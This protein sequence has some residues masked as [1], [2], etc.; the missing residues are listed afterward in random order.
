L[1]SSASIAARV[2]GVV[3]VLGYLTGAVDGPVLGVLGGLALLTFG[4][5]LAARPGAELIAPASFGILAGA[6]GVVAL[7]WGTL[8]L[9]GI[10]GI[11]AVLGPIITVEP[12]PVAALAGAALGAA[13]VAAGLGA[14]ELVP[15]AAGPRWWW[16]VEVGTVSATLAVL[17]VGSP[18]TGFD[19]AGRWAGATALLAAVSALS[20]RVSAGRS[21]GLRLLLLGVCI[22]V[23]GAAA[24]V[25]GMHA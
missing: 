11:H 14:A 9:P 8:D 4:R 7:R 15:E 3:A 24:V 6:A 23:V 25:T 20:A 22:V 2:A 10:G 17:F 5:S 13:A 19:H 1:T 12:V 16:W 21:V 18:F